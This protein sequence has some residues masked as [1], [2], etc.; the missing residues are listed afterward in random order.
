MVLKNKIVKKHGELSEF[1]IQEIAM[2]VDPDLGITYIVNEKYKDKIY[3]KLIKI[4]GVETHL[5]LELHM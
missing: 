4:Y 3:I 2:S 5:L 1:D